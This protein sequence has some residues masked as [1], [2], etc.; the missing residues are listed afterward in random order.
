[1][2]TAWLIGFSLE[3]AERVVMAMVGGDWYGELTFRMR[4]RL[5]TINELIGSTPTDA[6]PLAC[7]RRSVP[8][9]GVPW[10]S[11]GGLVVSCCSSEGV[12]GV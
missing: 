4:R 9:F 10:H 12:M 7:L 3:I 8:I 5:I 1:M 11:R 6:C 2:T